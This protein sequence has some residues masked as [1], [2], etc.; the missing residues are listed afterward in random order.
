MS[1][2]CWKNGGW[3]SVVVLLHL[4]YR[5]DMCCKNAADVENCSLTTHYYY[6]RPIRERMKS[7]SRFDEFGWDTAFVHSS[8]AH[9][10]LC[11]LQRRQIRLSLFLVHGAKTTLSTIY[12]MMMM[13]WCTLVGDAPSLIL[14]TILG[15][16]RVCEHG[17][18]MLY[19][20]PDSTSTLKIPFTFF[21]SLLSEWKMFPFL[22]SRL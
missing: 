20:P 3:K 13:E 17:Q 7:Y 4:L 5:F 8:A 12:L 21:L 18:E 1:L 22:F 19:F 2:R 9:F 14:F 6:F 10:V 15:D 16:W 11:S